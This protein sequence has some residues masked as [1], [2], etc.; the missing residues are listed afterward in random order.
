MNFKSDFGSFN[1]GD[2]SL[3]L[4]IWSRVV[5]ITNLTNE[6]V[7]AKE[8]VF[9][10]DPFMKDIK[11]QFER[12][13]KRKIRYRKRIQ[14]LMDNYDHLY[15]VTLTFS[16]DFISNGNFYFHKFRKKFNGLYIANEDYGGHTDRLHYHMLCTTNDFKW[17]YGF[18]DIKEFRKNIQD[19][20]KLGDYINKL[21]N[22][23]YKEST[24]KR[25]IWYNFK[26]EKN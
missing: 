23:A 4:Y 1:V 24:K 26:I 20:Y 21:S 11:K 12:I 22:H 15:F 9:C 16:N 3:A 13:K 18:T 2:Y 8:V 10:N 7:W 5:D 19:K 14:F 6:Q 17:N 25:L